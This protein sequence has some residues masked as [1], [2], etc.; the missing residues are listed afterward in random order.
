MEE[1]TEL[2]SEEKV[3]VPFFYIQILTINTRVLLDN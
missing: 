2:G 3:S 1:V